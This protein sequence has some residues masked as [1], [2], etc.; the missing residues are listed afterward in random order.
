[1]Q[2]LSFVRRNKEIIQQI[3]SPN[4][5]TANT[6]KRVYESE[7]VV[8]FY[9]EQKDL[10]EPE[11]TILNELRERLP[12]MSMLDIGVG[13]GRTTIHFAYIAKEYVGIDYSNKMVN[14]CIKKFKNFPKK[15]SFLN[16]DARNMKNF[17]DNSF[18]FILFSLNG[19]DY[20]DHE[21]R[22]EIFREIRRLIRDGGY[23]CFSTHNLNSLKE[24]CSFHLS[25]HPTLLA[26]RTFRLLQIR[27][28]NKRETWKIAKNFPRVQ[29][30][31]VMFIDG[32]H[33]FRLKTY[34]ISPIEQLKQLKELGY[35]ATKMYS[36]RDGREIENPNE[37]M[38]D[39]VYF[40][41]C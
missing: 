28:P 7:D 14:A 2:I 12:N 3:I 37:A 39:W 34:Y 31:H 5:V 8:E 4:L 25:K 19:I 32:A 6:N 21:E 26:L 22:I 24:R 9:T 36:S 27:I 41:S 20:V 40:L 10:Q 16:V 1:L 38:D 29:Q 17:K 33:N 11:L 35:S 13:T 18:D 15:I 30:K 23:F